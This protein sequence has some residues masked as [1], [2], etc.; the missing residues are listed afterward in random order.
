[1]QYLY[2]NTG[3]HTFE[4]FEV[5]R[6]AAMLDYGTTRR[7]RLKSALYPKLKK[8]KVFKIVEGDPLGFLKIQFVAKYQKNERGTLWRHQKIVEKHFRK[9]RIMRRLNSLIVPKNVKWEPFGLFQHP[10][11]C[12]ISKNLKENMEIKK[13]EKSHKA[14]K[15]ARKVSLRKPRRVP[16]SIFF[17]TVR[18]F[19]NI[20]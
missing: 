12:N 16:P 10:S 17:G 5:S 1:M 18:L 11:S 7:E 8:R 13:F 6:C 14:E 20:F 2:Q 15:R 3:K 9:K 4:N 19:S